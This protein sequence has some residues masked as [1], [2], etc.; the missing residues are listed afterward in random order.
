M[1]RLMFN[2]PELP[3]KLGNF[4]ISSA[5]EHKSGAGEQSTGAREQNDDS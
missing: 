1:R 5:R 2:T 4:P 3:V